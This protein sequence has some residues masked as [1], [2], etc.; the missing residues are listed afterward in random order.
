MKV[1]TNA[2]STRLLMVHVKEPRASNIAKWDTLAISHFDVAC[3]PRQGAPEWALWRIRS[4]G[5][6][7]VP[8]IKRL[9]G[10]IK[11]LGSPWLDCGM[12][13][14]SLWEFFNMLHHESPGQIYCTQHLFSKC[15]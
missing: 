7:Y 1:I 10:Q 3:E 12:H 5:T 6:L 13:L 8:Q 11:N 4:S 9:W 14:Y 15:L 2:P